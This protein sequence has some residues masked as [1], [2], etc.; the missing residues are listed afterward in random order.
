MSF[1]TNKTV[2]IGLSG[3][4]DSSVAALLLKRQGYEVIGAYI[5]SFSDKATEEAMC[6]NSSREGDKEIARIMALFLGIR[7][8]ILDYKDEYNN[9]VIK[10]MI[11]SYKK[12]LTPNPDTLCNKLIKFPF[13]WKEAR[14]LKAD[15]IATGHYAKVKKSKSSKGYELFAGKDKTKDQSYFLYSLSQNDLSH[16]LFPLGN[17]T[18]AEVRKIAKRNKFPNYNKRGT[19]GLCFVG[20]MDMFA[21]LKKNIPSKTGKVL[22]PEGKIIGTHPGASYFTIGQRIGP[23]L[24]I[25]LN[26]KAGNQKLYVAEKKKGNILIVAPENHPALKRRIVSI[27]K[28]HQINPKDKIPSSNLKAR[29][30]HLGSLISGRLLKKRG[31][32]FFAFKKPQKAIACGQAIVVYHKSKVVGGGEISS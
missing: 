9:K 4:V 18:K 13:L 19:T 6:K 17:L 2:L 7:F 1:K 21:Y 8:I 3:G 11:N 5:D 10:P 12:G 32:Y 20:K 14:K 22:S 29:I 28:F 24:S 30:R 15:F 25:Q 27:K 31:N 16:T 23:R 26:K